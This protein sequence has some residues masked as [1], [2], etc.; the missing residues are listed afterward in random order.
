MSL[1]LLNPVQPNHYGRWIVGVLFAASLSV[2]AIS[3]EAEDAAPL[4]LVLTGHHFVPDKLVVPAHQKFK[5]MVQNADDTD[6]EFE[7]FELNREILVNKGQTISVFLGPL[8]PGEYPVF[9]DFHQE[10]RGVLVAK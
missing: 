9:D 4:T 8:E 3:A 5:L 6:D 10:A 7:S 1:S 2:L